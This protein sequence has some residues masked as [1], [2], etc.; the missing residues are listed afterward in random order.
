MLIVMNRFLKIGIVVSFTAM[1]FVLPSNSVDFHFRWSLSL[2]GR[3]SLPAG[4]QDSCFPRRSRHLT[5]QSTGLHLYTWF[6]FNC[7]N[8]VV[9]DFNTLF[10]FTIYFLKLINNNFI[11]QLHSRWN[12]FNVTHRKYTS[13]LPVNF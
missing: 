12:I 9:V 11:D 3:S 5:F 10:L 4:A 2:L 7:S 1:P 6:Y 8:T 13:S